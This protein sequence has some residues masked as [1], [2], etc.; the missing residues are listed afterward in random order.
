[1]AIPIS[2][3]DPFVPSLA[4]VGSLSG[5]TR[6]VRLPSGY[7]RIVAKISTCGGGK[8]SLVSVVTGAASFVLLY[9]VLLKSS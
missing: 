2:D 6:L 9:K 3:K 4:K 8:V 7:L 5:I 1:M